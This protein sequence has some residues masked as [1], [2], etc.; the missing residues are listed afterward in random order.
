MS[1]NQNKFTNSSDFQP[2][3]LI[4]QTKHEEAAKRAETPDNHLRF[5]G[6]PKAAPL[7]DGGAPDLVTAADTAAE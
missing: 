2:W 6:V 4:L 5:W 3:L 1:T 7:V